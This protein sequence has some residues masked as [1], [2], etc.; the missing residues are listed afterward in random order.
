[1]KT[2]RILFAL[3]ALMALPSAA[4]A[5]PALQL[6]PGA[7]GS[8]SYDNGT[9]TWV[10]QSNPFSVNAYANS[11]TSGA[12][13]AY[14]WDSAGAATQTA[15]LVISA[16]P[17][18]NAD[19]FDVTVEN[20]G[21]ALAIFDSGFGAPPLEDSNSLAPHG[22]FDTYF[23]IYQFNFDGPLTSI[24]NTEPGQSGSGDGFV[25][26][27][28][29]MINSMVDPVYGVHMDLFVVQGDGTYTPGMTPDNK[30]VN[31]FAPFSHDAESVPNN[32]D[33]PEPSSLL[34]LLVGFAGA[35]TARRR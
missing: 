31:A 16:I 14:A 20:D 13:G 35:L 27:F 10:N 3:S 24:G 22:I 33:V 11:N 18:V 9:Q 26:S 29:V 25:E 32:F 8:W 15:Y 7:V 21:G 6:G 12:N 34:L 5:L 19:A 1:M 17:M 4:L 23:E 28:D 30:L 2:L